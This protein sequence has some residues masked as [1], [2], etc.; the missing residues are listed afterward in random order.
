L[1][2]L[3]D[4]PPGEPG[5]FLAEP[6]IE[7]VYGWKTVLETMA[8]LAQSGLLSG[9]LVE[10]MA[11]F[12]DEPSLREH[13]F[14]KDRHPY[15]H[16]VE[17]WQQL[18]RTPPRSVIITSGTG[19][20][21]TECFLVPIL[22]DL[23]RKR[24]GA[25]RLAGVRALFLYPLNALINNQRDR[26][27]AWCQPFK[28]DL[29]FCLYKGDTP[30]RLPANQTRRSE[31]V[32]DR[33]SLRESPPP[34]LITNSTMLEYMLV[35][36]KDAP[37]LEA[38]KGQLRWIVL[39]EAHSYIGSAAAELSLLL[40]RVLHGFDV[41]SEQVRFVATSATI[42][43]GGEESRERLRQFM[44]D[45][46]GVPEDRVDVIEEQRLHPA[47]PDR[48]R[49]VKG[50]LPPFD[51][52]DDLDAES[53][54]KVL[55]SNPGVRRMRDELLQK[56]AVFLSDLVRARN[57]SSTSND[58]NRVSSD[59]RE[60]ALRLLDLG[61]ADRRGEEAFFRL[62]VHIFHRA[63]G[64]IW[65]C[66]NGSCSG[67]QGGLN[68]P[69]W[70]FGAIFFERR[71]KCPECESVV[72]EL[73]LCSECGAEYLVADLV[74]QD[75][76]WLYRA[77][78]DIEDRSEAD[79]YAELVG[80]EQTGEDCGEEAEEEAQEPSEGKL[81][82]LT[83]LGK[84][85]IREIR[86]N[87]SDGTEVV[88]G[89][90]VA[91]GELEPEDGGSDGDFRCHRCGT[92]D[93]PARQ[94]FRAARRG[95][96]FFL[97]SI[98]PIL[99]DYMPAEERGGQRWPYDGRKLI[100]FTDSRQGTA[101][102]SLNAQLDSE[103]NYIR[104]YVYHQLA[105]IRCDAARQKESGEE[106]RKKLISE[107]EKLER[108][109]PENEFL[110]EV[111]ED[112]RRKLSEM[113]ESVVGRI[114]WSEL[115]NRLANNE[116]VR[117]WMLDY[118]RNIPLKDLSNNEAA[119]FCL[120]RE[121]VRR[122]KRQNNLETLGLVALHYPGLQDVKDEPTPWMRK[123]IGLDQWRAFLKIC[124]D[125]LVRSRTAV[126]VNPLFID[127]MGGPVRPKRITGPASPVATRSIIRWPLASNTT[128]RSRIVQ[129]LAR[130]LGLDPGERG[131]FSDL[132]ICLEQAW[133]SVRR[134]LSQQ[135]E[136]W[137]L[138]LHKQ[139]EFLEVRE[140]WLCPVTRRVLDT[141]VCGITPYLTADLP[142][143]DARCE[144]IRLPKL[145]L[146]FWKRGDGSIASRK[147]IEDWL[148]C[149]EEVKDLRTRGV[150]NDLSSRLAAGAHYFQV[151][152]HSAQ[153]DAQRL[154]Q[155][156]ERFKI[157]RINVLSCSTTM[158]L[159][160]DI[161]GLSA[162]AMNNAPPGPS[163]FLQRAGRAGRRSQARAFSFTLCKNTP[164]GEAVFRSPMWPFETPIYVSRVSLSSERIVQRQLNS[165]L[166]TRFLKLN[167][168]DADLMKLECGSF[169]ESPDDGGKSPSEFFARW[170]QRKALQDDWV[171]SGILKLCHRSC[172]A[173][174]APERLTMA[175]GDLIESLR[176][177]WLIELEP[178]IRDF[179]SIGENDVDKPTRMAIGYQI[180]RMREEYL[181]GEL[182]KR[183]FLP[184][185]GFPTGVVPFITTTIE[186]FKGGNR[187]IAER[188]TERRDEEFLFSRGYPTR[189]LLMGLREYA[190]GATIVIDGRV[191]HSAGLTLNW[192]TPAAKTQIREIQAINI[193]W[194]CMVCGRTGS[195]RSRI[196]KCP[197]PECMGD[198]GKIEFHE[199]LRP[200]GFAVDISERPS[201]D[202]TRNTYI[203]VDDPWI[204]MSDSAW[205]PLPASDLGRYR[206]T[207]G[208]QIILRSKGMYGYGYA[209]CLQ[210]GR[211]AP[212][213]NEAPC[214]IPEA[215][216]DHRPLRGGKAKNE[217][218]LCLG[219]DNPWKIK[220]HVWLGE[221]RSTDMFEL[222]LRDPVS[223]F[224]RTDDVQLSSLAVAL[225]N[226]LAK[227]LG[228]DD[229][230]IGWATT[231][232]RVRENEKLA[233]SMVLYDTASGGAGFCTRA[234]LELPQL[235]RR[236]K[237]A[238]QCPRECDSAC[239]AC[240]LA[241]DT[242]HFVDKLNRHKALE[243]LHSEFISGL[244]VPTELRVFGDKTQLEFEPLPEAI[245]REL[246]SSGIKQ[247]RIGLSGAAA[248]W[249]LRGWAFIRE[250]RQW[251]A[252]GVRIM[253]IL[254]EG[255]TA[256]LEPAERNALAALVEADVLEVV[257]TVMDQLQ[258]S[259]RL[260]V[261]LGSD[262]GSIKFAVI[263]EEVGFPSAVWEAALEGALTVK[264]VLESPLKAI[265]AAVMT[266]QTL[267]VNP[268][269][270]KAPI[271]VTDD[272]DGPIVSF[273]ERLWR[274]L[275][276]ADDDLDMRLSTGKRIKGFTYIDRYLYS[277]LVIRCLIEVIRGLGVVTDGY[278]SDTNINVQTT[279]TTSK[280][281]GEPVWLDHDWRTD[282]D[283]TRIFDNALET[284]RLKGKL[285]IADRK[286]VPHART[287]KLEWDD[288]AVWK[289]NLDEGFGFMG[290]RGQRHDFRRDE[291]QQGKDLVKERYTVESR[292]KTYFYIFPLE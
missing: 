155:F 265:D 76:N 93:R 200:A 176:D 227:H 12:S 108:L 11:T 54:F 261:S 260:D 206:S 115:E 228:V 188:G 52:L 27:R 264:A 31:E 75:G 150:W 191:L 15:T 253:L 23:I 181:L 142:T 32:L 19:S 199:Y 163:N 132:N 210:C 102:F 183:S 279:Q 133:I 73:C 134:L 259:S 42:A 4:V 292:G 224:M 151:A 270:S 22:D 111:L 153:Q 219:N 36:Q 45:L 277:P 291:P 156:E 33:K 241:Y 237:E 202:L 129:L 233:R 122:P 192:K 174:A 34:L 212:E 97:R 21:K 170:L 185:Y 269:G 26:L 117:S 69:D 196:E 84:S 167:A 218:G 96:P 236:A 126:Q 267:R 8:S 168:K 173:G 229:R 56:K 77:R 214:P 275:R 190:P 124:L 164:H 103:R 262:V 24:D 178:L 47:L 28:G 274:V 107:I 131:S 48:Y 78:V 116:E 184:G 263:G 50:G 35:R 251:S 95:A 256:A 18:R 30:E 205:L 88:D 14:P 98:I 16:Q 85:G 230:E 141:T 284:I 213:E 82:L 211:A 2:E 113:S 139:A 91:L 157:G 90:G 121:F 232:S 40:R 94:L 244:D 105:A 278:D 10:A 64:G 86:I 100:T 186:D 201:N 169:F 189:D 161:G 1:R 242:Q 231:L 140:A 135:Q 193:A 177:S 246:Q 198:A 180:K 171:L 282:V 281:F 72:F 243:L 3:L 225:R 266:P 123:G 208:G 207:P 160:V 62:R 252:D 221:T 286:V 273:G 71:T 53:L 215:L 68:D 127:W 182:A 87:P 175:S 13:I 65:A 165:L 245:S 158:E 172:L 234:A 223:G 187:R 112:K 17:S 149:S 255:I 287:M 289:L 80:E 20:G 222:Q 248:K 83:G 226:A 147:E 179:N 59:E 41:S 166:L 138:E 148:E 61:S 288:G 39:D 146:A 70:P 106:D 216:R 271:V 74:H 46:A 9:Q 203:P 51:E 290:C 247:V 81:R 66:V 120:L 43:G 119:R 257:E 67:R 6:V 194:R 57:G 258:S 63:H 25:G 220:R 130:V 104:S 79:E 250:L 239:H 217:Q 268:E 92:K 29:R 38:S 235:F 144:P 204:S 285:T 128:R 55:A 136:G 109:V 58:N 143:D 89:A 152:E 99:L 162:V 249:D 276:Q 154:R 5:A 110:R 238:L 280:R 195:S 125:F 60:S 197:S 101:R 37:I 118:W 114:S 254:K 44:A 272:L 49:S 240:L 209:V 145:P 159:G 7:G 137:T 283:K